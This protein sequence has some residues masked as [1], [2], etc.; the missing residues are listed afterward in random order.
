MPHA[1]VQRDE[2]PS[3]FTD[4]VMITVR[5]QC[6]CDGKE[7]LQISSIFDIN[8]GEEAFIWTMKRM[9]FDVKLEVKQHMKAN[10]KA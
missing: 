8:L 10:A 4:P 6:P 1:L 5:Y 9:L 3:A 2:K 7:V